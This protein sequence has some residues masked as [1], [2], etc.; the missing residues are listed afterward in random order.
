[1]LIKKELT[2]I[3][4]SLFFKINLGLLFLFIVSSHFSFAQK[5]QQIDSLKRLI[6]QTNK[7]ES[8]ELYA[9]IGDQYVVSNI[10][11]A[12]YYFE[13]AYNLASKSNDHQLLTHSASGLGSAY[14]YKDQVKSAEYY[15]LSV[16]HAQDSKNPELIVASH[17]YLGRFYLNRNNPEKAQKEY[18]KMLA[19][20]EKADDSLS[21]A[22]AYNSL[23]ITLMMQAKYDV[24]LDY[25]K[26]ALA[27]KLRFKDYYSAS[28]T[29]TNIGLYYK[30]IGRYNE[31]EDY[32]KQSL[33]VD[34]NVSNFESASNNYALL[35]ELFYKTNDFETSIEYYLSSIEY[36]DSTKTY[37]NKKEAL[38]GLSNAYEKKGEHQK[39]IETLHNYADLLKQEFNENNSQ[40]IEELTTRY[41]TE[42]KDALL[43]EE[44]ANNALKEAN[45]RYLWLG[46]FIAFGLVIIV[47]YSL[48]KVRIAKKAIDE[49]KKLVEEKNQE[50]IDSINYSKRLQ[51]AVLAP[52]MFLNSLI[53]NAFLIYEP[54]DIVAGD[55][56]WFKKTNNA[57]YIGVA[58]CTG[59]GVPG[60]L[61]SF[62]CNSALNR[63]L[64]EFKCDTPAE[65]LG[66]TREIVIE[67]F[68]KNDET[69]QDGM[70][71][72]LC[73][74]SN[75]LK[76]IQYAGAHNP[77][78]VI[79]NGGQN[80]EEI[81]ADKQPVGYHS[82]Q[83]PYTNHALN[84]DAGD[85]VFLFSDGFSDQFGGDKG[86]KFKSA[87]FKRLLLSIQHESMVKQKELVLQSFKDWKSH[88]EQVDD[89]CVVGFEV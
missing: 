21:I 75:D 64:N 1:M 33:E 77:L 63:S 83:K 31:A 29:M 74:I 80:I 4:H 17:R 39:A 37:F 26:K 76:S 19:Y 10:D 34:L 8:G 9:K 22:V 87:N 18:E 46:L 28:A 13:L 73:R 78:W 5:Q 12:I 27:I 49:Q 45:I 42:K 50:I 51:N 43:R 84:I 57:I 82:H 59:H 69:I 70:D 68:C 79:R 89:V 88:F 60:A 53:E 6:H 56:Y 61:V 58:D 72:S 41:E 2:S 65:V 30:D 86:K 3:Y 38:I 14:E 7:Q 52:P 81:K 25:W 54:K 48:R 35:G 44:Q 36:A 62:I 11:S 55:F 16:E 47:L 23:G 20:A 71:I 32:L 24:G 66:K 40:I 85:R 15:L 67:E